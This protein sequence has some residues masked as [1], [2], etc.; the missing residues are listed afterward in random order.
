MCHFQNDLNL[1]QAPAHQTARVLLWKAKSAHASTKE[2]QEGLGITCSIRILADKRH[3]TVKCVRKE[4]VR[5][6][7]QVAAFIPA[8]TR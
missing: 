2:E 4:V 8:L 7:M 6:K 1:A 3:L 5:G